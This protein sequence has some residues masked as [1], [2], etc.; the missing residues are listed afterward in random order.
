MKALPSPVAEWIEIWKLPGGLAQRLGDSSPAHE[1]TMRILPRTLTLYLKADILRDL[2]AQVE[3]A[4]KTRG[5]RVSETLQRIENRKTSLCMSH[6]KGRIAQDTLVTKVDRLMS[7]YDVL[8]DRVPHTPAQLNKELTS[9]AR[10]HSLE[11]LMNLSSAPRPL[12]PGAVALIHAR[13]N[14]FDV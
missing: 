13:F 8:L 11:S 6:A 12:Q 7:L 9:L 2:P 4:R 14:E 5:T 1:G 10:A 3:L